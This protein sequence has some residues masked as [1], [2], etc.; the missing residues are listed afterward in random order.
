MS[1]GLLLFI[2]ASIAAL[3][4]LYGMF[5]KAGMAP[6]KGLIPL[7]NTWCMVNKMEISKVW[8]FL[9]L[10]PIAGQFITIWIFIKFVEHFGRFGLWHHFLTVF[11][12]FHLFSIPRLF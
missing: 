12:S 1:I 10:I 9:Q 11:F 7:Y 3:I 6:W 2:I 5:K 8:F 4:G